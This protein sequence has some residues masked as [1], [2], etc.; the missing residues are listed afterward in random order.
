MAKYTWLI[1]TG[2]GY[3]TPGK[4]YK[5]SDGLEIFEYSVNRKIGEMLMQKMDKA[6]LPYVRINPE[7][8]DVSNTERITRAN[9]HY[10]TYTNAVYL[11]IHN[12]AAGTEAAEG[13]EVFT[14][15]GNTKSD[16]IATVFIEEYKKLMPNFKL[17]SDSSDGDLDKEANFTELMGNMPAVLIE[18]LFFT[19]RREAEYL[20][21]AQ[22]QDNIAQALFNAIQKLET[23]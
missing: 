14:T 20:L 1:S 21:S 18:C 2:H 17:R 19:N 6:N 5:F 16:A 22:G 10:K 12:N 9:N 3:D 8:K 11:S 23:T 7:E 15:K 4:R 13:W